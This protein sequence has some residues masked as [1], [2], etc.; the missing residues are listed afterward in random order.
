MDDGDPRET[1]SPGRDTS[2]SARLWERF[3][4]KEWETK[5]GIV[6]GILGVVAALIAVLK[7]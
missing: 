4:S 2:R 3:N 7:A 5:A 6:A 1:P